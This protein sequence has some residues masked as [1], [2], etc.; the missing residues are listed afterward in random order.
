MET[1]YQHCVHDARYHTQ[2]HTLN[3]LQPTSPHPPTTTNHPQALER[4]SN[5]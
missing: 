1:V 5:E 4:A 2:V 3:A